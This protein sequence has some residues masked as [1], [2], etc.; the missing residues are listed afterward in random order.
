M[1]VIVQKIAQKR[2]AGIVDIKAHMVN[3]HQVGKIIVVR[4]VQHRPHHRML[5]VRHIVQMLIVGIVDIKA[6]ICK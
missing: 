5:I 1:R 6:R 4:T 3:H 2:H